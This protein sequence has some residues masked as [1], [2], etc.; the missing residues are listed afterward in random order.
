MYKFKEKDD[1]FVPEP[2][3]PV[4]RLYAY[5]KHLRAGIRIYW[6]YSVRGDRIPVDY[7][8]GCYDVSKAR[9]HRVMKDALGYNQEVDPETADIPFISKSNYQCTHDGI[10]HTENCAA[11]PDR[12]YARYLDN[13]IEG[14]YFY[15]RDGL[16]FMIL[17]KRER[18]DF[19]MDFISGHLEV[20]PIARVRQF[21]A[22]FGLD[23]GELDILWDEFGR[24][25]V[26]DVNN[27][28]GNGRLF[29][30][31]SKADRQAA[32]ELYIRQIKT[33]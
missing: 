22:A 32:K 20:G 24:P 28:A 15:C 5:K 2:I 14:R 30:K 26:I 33:L 3:R 21:C 25:Y 19:S 23:F 16:D 17:K 6:N 8:S 10:V 11:N 12:V 29:E 1:R 31:L 27:V 9:V 13:S 7:N 4:S 18:G